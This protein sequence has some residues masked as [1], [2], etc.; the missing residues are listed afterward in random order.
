MNPILSIVIPTKDRYETL[1]ILVETLLS[2]TSNTFELVVQDNTVDNEPIKK[3]LVKYEEDK[4][5]VYNHS[6]Q[7]MSAP[8]NCDRGMTLAKGE[9]IIIL[10]DDDAVSEYILDFCQWMKKNSIDG[11]VSE[12]AGYYWPDVAFK[13]ALH[14]SW[15]G[16]LQYTHS[17]YSMYLIDVESELQKVKL[18]GCTQMYRLPRAYHGV[19]KRSVLRELQKETGSYFPGPTIDMSSAVGIS[20]LIG[21]VIYVSIPLIISGYSRKSMAGASLRHEHQGRIQDQAS[22]PRNTYNEWNM[23]VPRYWSGPTIWAQTYLAASDR[24]SHYNLSNG[25]DYTYLYAACFTYKDRSHKQKVFDAIRY[26]ADNKSFEIFRNCIQVLFHWIRITF[27]RLGYLISRSLSNNKQLRKMHC[28]NIDSASRV[29]N[30]YIKDEF[31]DDLYFLW[32]E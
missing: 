9:Y 1:N 8:E 31:H 30:Q 26:N 2:W 15:V 13:Y 20:C 11:L 32:D 4:R 16:Q 6:I 3:L 10:G 23:N 24:L 22:L 5:L 27:K 25:F 21:K 28:D 29:V 18:S 12:K 7:D 14:D 19:V 17:D